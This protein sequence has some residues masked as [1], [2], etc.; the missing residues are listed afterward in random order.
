MSNELTFALGFVPSYSMLLRM[1]ALQRF[2]S[3]AIFR[4]M[5][6]FGSKLAVA[7]NKSESSTSD[8][9]GSASVSRE[10]TQK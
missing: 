6:I 8:F 2:R 3:L 4:R 1:F 7:A 5:S 9:N 10:S